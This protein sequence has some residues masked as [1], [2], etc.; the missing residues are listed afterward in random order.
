MDENELRQLRI[1]YQKDGSSGKKIIGIL[2]NLIK[3][4]KYYR[5]MK[6]GW[7]LQTDMVLVLEISLWSYHD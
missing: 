5:E 7:E 6:I 4:V 2:E 3:G 1:Y